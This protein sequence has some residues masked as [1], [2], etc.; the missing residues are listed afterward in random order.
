MATPTTPENLK[1]IDDMFTT[2][3]DMMIRLY[4]RWQDEQ[5]YENIEDYRL[6][7]QRELPAGFVITKMTKRPFGFKFDIGTDAMYQVYVT[8]GQLGWKRI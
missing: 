6:P 1:R 4:N 2:I 7:I 8:A 3:E 5:D